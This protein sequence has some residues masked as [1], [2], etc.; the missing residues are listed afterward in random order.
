MKFTDPKKQQ[1][2]EQVVSKVHW[3]AEKE[4]VVRWLGSEK[5]IRGESAEKLWKAACR[6][7]RAAVRTRSLVILFPSLIALGWLV[8]FLY[9]QIVSGVSFRGGAVALIWVAGIFGLI[10]TAKSLAGIITGYTRGSVE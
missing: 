6:K 3:G 10:G 9:I 8:W 4:E 2:F 1:I 7:K 5:G